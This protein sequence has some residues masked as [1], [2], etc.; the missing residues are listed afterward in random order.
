MNRIIEIYVILFKVF[1]NTLSKSRNYKNKKNK[2][3][4]INVLKTELYFQQ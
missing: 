3:L 2:M 1:P 4:S